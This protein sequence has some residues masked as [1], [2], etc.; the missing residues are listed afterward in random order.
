VRPSAFEEEEV[1][2]NKKIIQERVLGAVA[3]TVWVA[4]VGLYAKYPTKHPPYPPAEALEESGHY[5]EAQ[6][7]RERLAKQ[8]GET[9]PN[10]RI[11]R[12]GEREGSEQE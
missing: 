7:A 2:L 12:N 10:P 11:H 1:S 9:I 5:A 4:C 6:H 8:R 3:L